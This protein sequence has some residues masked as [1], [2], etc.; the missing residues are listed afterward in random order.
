MQRPIG[1]RTA[2]E[3]YNRF[4]EAVRAG[5]I[6]P[7]ANL[8]QGQLCEALGMSLTPL[9]ETLILLEEYGLVETKPRSGLAVVFPD[10]DFYRENIQFRTMIE[11]YCLKMGIERFSREWIE[12]LREEHHRCRDLLNDEQRYE[13]GK[14][15]MMALDQRLHP[16]IV[17]ILENR[18]VLY[19]HEHVFKNMNISREVHRRPEFRKQL[20]DTVD[21][22]MD[23]L[24]AIEARDPDRAVAA[25][26]RH[27]QAS[28]HRTFS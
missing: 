8:T 18:A 12:E 16:D 20:L 11:T 14:S 7:G 22:H 9:R 28:T 26:E 15:G 3:G 2:H 19:A 21:E 10:V 4:V 6:E 27:F 13:E 5:K 24:N 25:L 1:N 17:A 23:I